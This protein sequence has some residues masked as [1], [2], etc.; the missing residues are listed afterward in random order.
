MYTEG[1][2]GN[3]AIKLIRKLKPA[4]MAFQMQCKCIHDSN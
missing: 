4:A 1:V 3:K 2:M